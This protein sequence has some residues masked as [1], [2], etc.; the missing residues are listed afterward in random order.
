[1]K[2]VLCTL[3]AIVMVMSLATTAFAAGSAGNDSLLEITSSTQAGGLIDT[4]IV[5]SD[6]VV[7]KETYLAAESMYI[8]NATASTVKAR[9]ILV[10]LYDYK[11]EE[12]KSSRIYAKLDS[13]IS[14]GVVSDL[15]VNGTSKI[16]W[17]GSNPVNCDEIRMEDTWTINGVGVGFEF[18]SGNSWTV[19]GSVVSSTA[20]WSDSF[21]DKWNIAHQYSNLDFNGYELYIKQNV[22]GY[23]T[24]STTTYQVS[25]VDSTLL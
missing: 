6:S 14:Y 1:M 3:L 11:E 19:S 17:L 24:F 5:N 20:T 21:E 8:E 25:A 18:G 23:F 13:D 22:T 10:N 12:V 7:D 2:K 15:R 9:S 4:V 16:C